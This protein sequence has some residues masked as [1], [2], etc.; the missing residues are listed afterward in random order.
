MES[1]PLFLVY[2][3]YKIPLYTRIDAQ[4]A[5]GKCCFAVRLRAADHTAADWNMSLKRPAAGVESCN[6]GFYIYRGYKIPLYT[7]IDAQLAE[8]KCCFAVCLHTADRA[9]AILYIRVITNPFLYAKEV[10]RCQRKIMNS[11]RKNCWSP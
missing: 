9:G 10:K 5:E 8:G 4:L 3:G 6:T 1:V 2:R 11:V 7:R